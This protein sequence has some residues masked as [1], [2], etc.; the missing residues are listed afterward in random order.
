MPNP[1]KPLIQ[2]HLEGTY[3][4]DRHG[5]VA[6]PDLLEKGEPAPMELG[7]EGQRAWYEYRDMFID[8]GVL[9]EMDKEAFYLLCETFDNVETCKKRIAKEGLT[10][11]SKRGG[12][13]KNPVVM[14]RDQFIKEQMYYLARF[15]MTP[16]D[17]GGIQVRTQ[18]KQGFPE[19][20]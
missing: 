4:A 20:P 6:E 18:K 8:S 1:G 17:R 3:R 16:S 14:I 7:P 13:A 19:K 15:G 5:N 2:H 10:Q 11:E 9:T 12:L